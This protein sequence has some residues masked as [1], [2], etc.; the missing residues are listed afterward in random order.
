MFLISFFNRHKTLLMLLGVGLAVRLAVLFYY[1]STHDWQGETWEYEEIATNLLEGRGYV[2]D[3]HQAVYRSFSVPVFPILCYA[4]H[5]IGGPGLSLYYVF[6]LSVALGVIVLTYAMACRWFGEQTALVAAFFVALEPGLVVY[7]SYKV[8]PVA[9]ST[10][11]LLLGVYTFT[12]A[13][14][15]LDK[16]LAWASGAVMGLGVMTRPDLIAVLAVVVLWVIL[17]RRRLFTV[18]RLATPVIVAATL[19]VAPWVIRNYYVHGQVLVTY[20]VSSELLWRGN[21]PNSTG[22]TV[23]LSNEGQFEAAPEEFRRKIDTSSEMEIYALFREETLRFI[24]QDPVGF[25]GRSIKKIWYFWWFSP[26]YAANYYGW[27]PSP[28]VKVYKLLHG[29]LLGLVLIGGWSV[30]RDGPNPTRRT[31]FYLLTVVLGVTLIHS[32]GYVEGR[33]RVLV[34]PIILMWA[35]HGL[36]T[37]WDMMI[38]ARAATNCR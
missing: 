20:S 1:L 21:N 24:S 31:S 34:M 7:H 9:L 37:C 5:L 26:T 23:T 13:A 28:L 6:H 25:L 4:L 11:L 15:S 12:R 8:D 18:L 36:V 35:A 17:E 3:F 16:R 30:V 14:D 22:T 29:I 38:R 10:F 32:I 33:H 27:L 2:F 19:V